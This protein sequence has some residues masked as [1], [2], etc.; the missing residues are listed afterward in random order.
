MPLKP[1]NFTHTP[2]RL[3]IILATSVNAKQEC[4]V[5]GEVETSTFVEIRVS[6]RVP[7][8]AVTAAEWS[9]ASLMNSRPELIPHGEK[10]MIPP[11]PCYCRNLDLVQGLVEVRSTP[12]T[13]ELFH[14]G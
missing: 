11:V 4:H 10:R 14:K 7:G 6:L 3:S 5:A 9:P 1:L 12:T 2:A 8:A 13:V